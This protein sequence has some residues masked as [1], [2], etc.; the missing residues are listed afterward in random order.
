M[1]SLGSSISPS[2]FGS[3]TGTVGSKSPLTSSVKRIESEVNTLVGRDH[4]F[5]IEVLSEK[6]W[7]TKFP[8]NVGERLTGG[9]AA[10]TTPS[11]KIF[12]RKGYEDSIAHELLHSTGALPNGVSDFV[13]EGIVQY[14][15]EGLNDKL[16]IESR[17]TYTDEINWVRNNLLPLVGSAK[18]FIAAY[19]KAEDKG[20]YVAD[21]I[22][23]KYGKHFSDKDDWGSKPK[24]SFQRDL[25][26]HV[27][28][29]P[30][31]EYLRKEKLGKTEKS[32][33]PDYSQAIVAK[34]EKT[35]EQI[36]ADLI[37]RGYVETDFEPGGPLYG[38]STNELI[39][40]ARDKRDD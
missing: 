19:T 38:Y 31:T 20:A 6:D 17:K 36:K 18:E 9:T 23:N 40:L 15:A 1:S 24:E 33:S 27:G 2:G 35:Y 22:F 12:I 29:D 14:F 32:L 7:E 25:L 8:S 10:I 4:K 11:G 21:T 34:E 26:Q 37:A 16:G 28:T 13:N 30:Y 5:D 39:D 3:S